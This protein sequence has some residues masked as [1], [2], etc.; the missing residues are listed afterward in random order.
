[1]RSNREHRVYC[2]VEVNGNKQER[3]RTAVEQNQRK[4]ATE[5]RKRTLTEDDDPPINQEELSAFLVGFFR[6]VQQRQTTE[7]AG[8]VS[9]TGYTTRKGRSRKALQ[10]RGANA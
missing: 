10:E 9:S 4:P 5:K 2:P 3:S 6:R 1:M 8:S 7:S